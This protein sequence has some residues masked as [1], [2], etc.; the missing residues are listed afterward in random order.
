MTI[1]E[2]S[3][4]RPTFIVVVFAV[5]SVLGIYSFVNI[6]YELLPKIAPPVVTIT[7]VYPGASPNEVETGV[8]KEI[9]DA[10]SSL[11]Q[12]KGITSISYEGASFVMVEFDQAVDIDNTLQNAQRKVNEILAQLPASVKSPVISKFALDEIPV[13]RI[14]ATSNLASKDFYQLIKDRVQPRISRVAG[15]SQVYTVG[16]VERE[17]RVNLNQDKIR[18]YGL[19]VLQVTELIKNSNLDFPT[20]RLKNDDNQYTVR[21]A[22]KFTSIEQI[23]NLVL[24]RGEKGNEIRVT[25]IADVEDGTKEIENILRFNGQESTGLLIQKQSDANAVE[26]S[27]LTRAELASLEKEYASVGLKFEVAQ[28]GSTFTISAANGVKVDLLIAIFLVAAVMLLFLHSIRNSF[29]VMLAIPASMLPTFILMY[30]F[31]FTFNLMTF[32]A[33]SLVVGILVDDSIVVLENIYHYLEQ[34]VEKRTAALKGRNEIGFAALAITLVDVVV[35][36]PLAFTGGMIGNIVQQYALVVVF[37]TLMSLFVSFTVTP[38]L[39]SRIGKHEKLAGITFIGRFA[40]WFEKKF[41]RFTHYYLLTLKWSLANRLKVFA[42]TGVLFVASLMLVPF[43]FIGGEFISQSDRGEFTVTIETTQGTSLEQT[44]YTTQSIEQFISKIPEVKNVYVNVGASSEGMLGQAASNSSEIT[45]ILYDKKVRVRGTEEVQDIIKRELRK[46]PAVTA[47]VNP[48]GIFGT[49]D[50]SPIRLIVKA[51]NRED[52][53]NSAQKI[54]DIMKN[55]PG[56]SDVRLSSKEGNPETNVV[57]DREKL[58]SFGLTIGEV[59]M[60]LRVALTGD[61]DSKFREGDTEYD[62]RIVIDEFDRSKADNLAHLTFVNRDGESIELQQFST[63]TQ[64]TGP[65]KLDRYDR[66]SSVVIYSNAVGRPS[67][68]IGE[69]IK[70]ALDKEKFPQGVEVAYDGDL[71]AQADSFGSLGLAIMAAILFMYLIMVALYESYLYPFIVLFSIPVAMVGAL[72]AL[73]LT[74]HSINIFSL[75]GIIMLIGLVG[76]NAILLVDRANQKMKEGESVYDSLMDAGEMRIRP[77]IMTTV[78]MV[79]GMLPIA[80]S[81]SSGSEWKA[82]LAWALIGGLTSSMFLTLVVV[83]VVY[84]YAEQMRAKVKKLFSKKQPDVIH[85]EVA[86]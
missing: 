28:D 74:M 62:L 83:P 6:N 34:G 63:V 25:D 12:I 55:I 46:Y 80:L 59:G 67:G 18:S 5:L 3:I 13:L 4:K 2:L 76:K 43:G 26:V 82:G 38:L 11:E 39:A 14:S 47:R 85:T 24:M 35:F 53:I 9:E 81:T 20:G 22:G 52:A 60:A 57:I 7:T 23:K 36:V 32:L 30:A 70:I 27:K 10:L 21:L 41:Q 42:F 65:N 54:S 15:V 29:I 77:I 64:T 68:S 8:T 37:S 84:S 19:S 40:I 16:G 79:F 75:L 31:D 1:T 73:A 17:I 78:A 44:N 72:L 33:L 50:D 61:D 51:P 86:E 45:V 56:T 66:N 71:K 69:D 58:S 48:I 49:A